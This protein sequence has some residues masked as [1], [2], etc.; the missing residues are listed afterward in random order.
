MGYSFILYV[1]AAF[2]YYMQPFYII[3]V[4]IIS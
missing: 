2:L 3:G 4:M 1:Y